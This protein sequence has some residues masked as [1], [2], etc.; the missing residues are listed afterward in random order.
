[1][2]SGPSGAETLAG[3]AAKEPAPSPAGA[4][5]LSGRALCKSYAM[6]DVRVRALRGVDF[7]LHERELVV[8]LGP[9]G[10]GKSTLLNILGGLDIPSSGQ[11]RYR[12]AG[13]LGRRR[14]H[15]HPLPPPA[16]RLHLPVLQPDPQP[17][18][19]RERGAG[20]RYRAAIR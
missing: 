9:S 8:L 20:R 4:V 18:R 1:M 10:S 17:D 12:D 15:A 3:A 14:G 2:E 5:V 11:V 13:A 7:A 19:A 16:R 6:G